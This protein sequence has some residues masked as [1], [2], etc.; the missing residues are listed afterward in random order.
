M[1]SVRPGTPDDRA[2]QAHRERCCGDRVPAAPFWRPYRARL[3]TPCSWRRSASHPTGMGRAS[4]SPPRSGSAA[5]CRSWDHSS[6]P[7]TA[8]HGL[9]VWRHSSGW[10]NRARCRSAAGPHR[11]RRDRR[12]PLGCVVS[13]QAGFRVAADSHVDS[14]GSGPRSHGVEPM[15]EHPARH[16]QERALKYPVNAAR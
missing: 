5:R 16:G 12:T 9:A 11:R 4:R 8:G 3:R 10:W 1:V 13:Q 15:H 7:S 6:Q 2:R 14:H